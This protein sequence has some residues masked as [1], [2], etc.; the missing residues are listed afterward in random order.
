MKKIYRI[1]LIVFALAV[2]TG[3]GSTVPEETMPLDLQTMPPETEA[4]E[5][6]PAETEAPPIAAMIPAE[7][8]Q[9]LT[10][11]AEENA[12]IYTDPSFVPA[13][14]LIP[15]FG[16]MILGAEGQYYFQ[17]DETLEIEYSCGV[18]M[19]MPASW[20]F[21]GTTAMDIPRM[22]AGIYSSKRMEYYNYL[23]RDP[24]SGTMF[25]EKVT[26]DGL[27][28][29]YWEQTGGTL[30]G[31]RAV[32]HHC[33]FPVSAGREIFWF[34]VYFLTFS[35]DPADYYEMHIQPMIDSIKITLY[36]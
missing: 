23:Y 30:E 20:D 19:E 21:E 26:A 5:T 32:W 14:I 4:P 17:K 8:A 36:Q 3:C 7:E 12:V 1:V 33:E 22:E 9:P 24:E 6:V 10:A 16:S 31:L 13:E 35:D 25:T 15:D 2:F 28:Y 29:R 18:T 11:I 27:E 34:H